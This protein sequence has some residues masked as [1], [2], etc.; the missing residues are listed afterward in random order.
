[1]IN[2]RS[3]A[4]S[5]SSPYLFGISRSFSSSSHLHRN[6]ITELNLYHKTLNIGIDNNIN[7]EYD[8]EI[9]YNSELIHSINP[10]NL[11]SATSNYHQLTPTNLTCFPSYSVAGPQTNT[12]SDL[13]IDISN[14]NFCHFSTLNFYS[15]L[16]LYYN[17]LFFFFFNHRSILLPLLMLILYNLN[18][19]IIN[20]LPGRTDDS[21]TWENSPSRTSERE[22]EG[23][24]YPY[25]FPFINEGGLYQ[26]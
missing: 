7:S 24:M 6:S 17:Y 22:N 16:D 8:I 4:L 13:N 14:I 25:P 19:L 2:S 23:Q 1:M 26:Y 11:N 12:I 15:Y 10:F 5:F 18:Y 20:S 21:Y 9:L 3:L